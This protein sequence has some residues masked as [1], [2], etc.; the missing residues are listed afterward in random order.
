[1][2]CLPRSLEST[3]QTTT[4]DYLWHPPPGL[5][6]CKNKSRG[7]FVSKMPRCRRWKS[8]IS[9][10][11]FVTFFCCVSEWG[12][13]VENSK[14]FCGLRHVLGESLVP[15]THVE[16]RYSNGWTCRSWQL[17]RLY[18]NNITEECEVVQIKCNTGRFLPGIEWFRNYLI[19][20]ESKESLMGSLGHQF[21]LCW[22]S[23]HQLFS[24]LWCQ[25]KFIIPFIFSKFTPAEFRAKIVYPNPS[26]W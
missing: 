15:C 9:S 17:E 14:R 13:K 1:M 10:D 23:T 6:S 16:I 22:C 5:T 4:G 25:L 2:L 11:F 21:Q 20:E 3:Q 12:S 24:F 7:K 19:K 18:A 8:L 26:I